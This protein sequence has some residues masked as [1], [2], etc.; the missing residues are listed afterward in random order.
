M[1]GLQKNSNLDFSS[2]SLGI[3]SP[4]D[5]LSNSYGEVLNNQT[6]NYR[7][8]NPEKYGLFCAK[9]FGPV[10]DY[11]C[12]CGKY[13]RIKYAGIVCEKCEVEVTTSSVRRERMGHLN[14]AVP[15][16]HI[17]FLKSQPSKIS[18]ALGVSM[19]DVS[20]VAYYQAY[21]ILDAG[22]S[23]FTKHQVIS[24]EEYA[25]ALD[26]YGDESF[27]VGI[28]GEGIREALISINIE[29]EIVNLA[30]EISES[31][32]KMKKKVAEKRLL[33]FSSFKTSGNKLDWMVMRYL[34]ILPP[35]LRPLV[36]L[37][38]GK[39]ATSD[40][41]DLYRRVI[42][43][44]NRLKRLMEIGA[45]A[46][47]IKNEKRM[48]QYSV[49][50]LLLG[51]Q[52]KVDD[53]KKSLTENL[54]GK[55][56]RFRQNIL[57]KRVDYSGRSVISVGPELKLNQCGLPIIMAME[58]FKPFIFSKLI[59]YGYAT[60]I[61]SCERFMQD[62]GHGEV[63]DILIE[64]ISDKVVLLN[65]APTLH[66]LGIQAFEII[67]V[68][69]KA[70]QLH[71]LVCKAFNADFDGDQMAVHLPISIEAQ[72]EARNLMMSTSNSLNPGDGNPII[73]PT[74]DSILGL[75]YATSIFVD[76]RA[77]SA[78]SPFFH[79]IPEVMMARENSAISWNT[80]IKFTNKGSAIVETCAGRLFLFSLV[81][82][83]F[84]LED[85]EIFNYQ[86]NSKHL[87]KAII[88]ILEK[89]GQALV[90]NFCDESMRFGF[91]VCTESGI[92]L[93][94]N[95][96]KIPESKERLIKHSFDIVKEAENQLKSGLITYK[97]KYNKV[98]D[99]WSRCIDNVTADMMKI[100]KDGAD[101][102]DVN[103]VYLMISSG[104]RGSES[105]LKQMA[106]M[107]GLMVKPS[108]DVIEAPIISNFKE[109]LNMMEYFNSAHGSRKGISD[110][111][112]KTANAGY[113]TRRLVDVAQD[114]VVTEHDCGTENGLTFKPLMVD[115]KIS[116]KLSE[117]VSG[118]VIA[119]DVIGEDGSV[120]L[121]KGTMI[122]KE[123]YD[124]IDSLHFIVVRSVATCESKNGV[125]A[126]CYG[127]DVA[128][129]KMVALGEPVGIVAAQSIGE[130]GTQLTLRTFQIGGISS[131]S[132]TKTILS[133][134]DGII[135]FES[136]DFSQSQDRIFTLKNNFKISI[137]SRHGNRVIASYSLPRSAELFVKSGQSI[138]FGQKIS[139]WNTYITPVMSEFDGYVKYIDM[140]EGISYRDRFDEN[141]NTSA[142]V[143][144]NSGRDGRYLMPRIG[145]A[146]SNGY[147]MKDANGNEVFYLLPEDTIV[148]C[149]D[150]QKISKN[151]VIAR[152]Q[153]D[154]SVIQDITGGLPIVDSIFE[155]RVPEK[156]AVISPCDGVVIIDT[157]SRLKVRLEIIPQ[158]KT[159][160]PVE[161]YI[162]K[163]D[164][165]KVDNGQKVFRGDT[166]VDGD[167]DLH[168]ILATH[169][170]EELI[171][172]MTSK[173][174]GVYGLQGS[175]INERHIEIIIK[176]MLSR[177]VVMNS[178]DSN[179]VAG[180]SVNMTIVNQAN[181][182]LASGG[183]K[184]VDFR[185]SLTGITK[186][187]I[188]T[189]SF[190]AAAAFQEVVKV[191]SSAACFGRKDDLRGCK[192]N[193]T[194]GRLIPIGTGF[195]E[196]KI[197]NP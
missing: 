82:V 152:I 182:L 85:F 192:E 96:I 14:L 126:M 21:I 79:N 122:S 97:E 8:F 181:D 34:P 68:N 50:E 162:K 106:G 30:N 60:S 4:E 144:T 173:I 167:L 124:V 56:G 15:V 109:G 20:R 176:R 166:L 16:V 114:V 73:S 129:R 143:V 153:T 107:K 62:R 33:F 155:A 84:N 102:H 92:S 184:L 118:R 76:D 74:K 111:A 3:S 139:S 113:L 89:Y 145:I 164:Y 100:I 18:T 69:G 115:G 196:S 45:P 26:A 94:L 134:S 47:I 44:N 36:P 147:L 125:C 99:E 65:R 116:K 163:G 197:L 1:Q 128:R 136:Q 186:I 63:L 174:Q 32:S 81:G 156:P 38:S 168:D 127:Q 146:D 37:D 105:Q 142:K 178:G 25:D 83:E 22:T 108:G 51:S 2:I 31:K 101:T 40:L 194:V 137:A 49:D 123:N 119:E 157:S 148:Q 95:D 24:D 78:D 188:N 58:L 191:L 193:I 43:R 190:L 55:G 52:T 180:D 161:I 48:L 160:D 177:C 183:K 17:W 13:K 11:E 93:G 66:R 141:S 12:L 7:N 27:K 103:S 5:I 41:N 149:E 112:L 80:K 19:K 54:K 23:P 39:F 46:I 140:V 171:R 189:D 42:N 71:P 61:R 150:G 165:I 91:K 187:S 90:V 185:P 138:V 29:E 53:V 104:A 88:Y 131:R 72:M 195:I 151:Q 159:V 121:T 35:D 77:N 154:L 28:G 57:G 9:I 10:K 133:E 64:V 130:P 169:G 132:S 179:F 175:N 70:I 6:I 117:I 87:S 75:F 110:T 59:T 135:R 98:T 86:F 120:V 67:L 170:K 172:F 158:D